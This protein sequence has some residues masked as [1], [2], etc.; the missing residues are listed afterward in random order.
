MPGVQRFSG[1][2]SIPVLTPA[3]PGGINMFPYSGGQNLHEENRDHISRFPV[4][5]FN[6]DSGWELHP[7]V[8]G[9]SD[10]RHRSSNFRPQWS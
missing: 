5:P 7:Q 10:P 8:S 4:M 2:M 6:R 9:G 1:Q 3:P